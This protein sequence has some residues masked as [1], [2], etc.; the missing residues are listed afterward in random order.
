MVTSHFIPYF[1]ETT[2]VQKLQHTLSHYLGE[3]KAQ[4]VFETFAQEKGVKITPN[5]PASP[6]LMYYVEQ[7]L[8]S[9]IGD[10]SAHLILALILHQTNTM[11]ETTF[12]LFDETIEAVEQR[13]ILQNALDHAKQGITVIDKNLMLV[14]VNKA[15]IGFADLPPRLARPGVNFEQIVRYNAEREYYGKGD[16]EE[17]VAKRLNYMKTESEPRRLDLFPNGKDNPSIVIEMVSNQLKG[18]GVITTYTDITLRVRAEEELEEAQRTLDKRVKERTKELEKANKDFAKAKALAEEANA[19][20]TRFLAAASHDIQ[21]PLHA[22]RLFA[23]TLLERDRERGDAQNAE[24]ICEAL[25]GVDEIINALFE[26]SKLDTGAVQPHISNFRL[27]EILGPLER[28]FRPQAEIKKIDLRFVKTTMAVRS[29][30]H[31]LRRALQNLI[32]NAIKYTVKGKVLVGVRLRHDGVEVNVCDTGLG[33][34]EN[35]RETVFQEFERLDEGKRTA[36]GLGL[37]LSIVDRILKILHHPITLQSMIRRGTVFRVML[38]LSPILPEALSAPALVY[39]NPVPLSV[40]LKSPMEGMIILTIDDEKAILDGMQ[41]LLGKWGCTV[42]TA[43]SLRTARIILKDR[44]LTPD[45]IIADYNLGPDE[46]NG[47]E[48]ITALRWAF[49]TSKPAILLTSDDKKEVIEEAQSKGIYLHHKP[50]KPAVL[51]ALLTQWR[52]RLQSP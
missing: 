12:T 49:G 29:D 45:V 41:S 34:P 5:M 3:S 37:G 31:L 39:S 26:I 25:D 47:I 46:G 19:S 15:F 23:E 36:K 16:V 30:R 24:R 27:D 8:A 14:A 50:V 7:A 52:M 18:G 33:I 6:A 28:E 2:S 22:A 43:E 40:E 38:P 48:A 17:L 44:A 4:R 11:S 42:I 20:K 21:Q 32:S 1:G 13:G 9:H 10:S 51:R 35:K